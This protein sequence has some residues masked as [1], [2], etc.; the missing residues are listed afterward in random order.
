[1]KRILKT[2]LVAAL[3]TATALFANADEGIIT[4]VDTVHTSTTTIT[5]FRYGI[6]G[7]GVQFSGK[8]TDFNFLA[9][10]HFGWGSLPAKSYPEYD[11]NIWKSF[12]FEWNIAQ[13][14]VRLNGAGTLFATGALKMSWDNIVWDDCDKRLLDNPLDTRYP[15]FDYLVGK[16]NKSKIRVDYLGL[17]IGL[18]FEK[19]NLTLYGTISAEILTTAKSKFK[20][21]SG[22][23]LKTGIKCPNKFRSCIEIGVAY[24]NIGL[25]ASYS[26]TPMFRSGPN[27]HPVNFGIVWLW[28]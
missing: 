3:L 18:T 23:V 14:N 22:N 21:E 16:G 28:G 19:D 4:S 6:E 17:P 11:N 12:N 25:Y 5:T 24:H 20:S 9:G 15:E 26:L 27:I 10:F 1:M 2:A 13:L 7:V 8:R